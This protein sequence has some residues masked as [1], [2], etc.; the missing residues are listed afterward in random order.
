[1]NKTGNK[2]IKRIVNATKYSV[3]G[4]KATWKTEE[5]FRQ[6][7][8]VAVIALPLSFWVADTVI[9]WLFLGC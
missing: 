5:A 7:I 4:V 9:E 3:D 1:M 2:G 8:G 6:E